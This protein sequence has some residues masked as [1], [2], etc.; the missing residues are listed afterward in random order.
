MSGENPRQISPED[1]LRLHPAVARFCAVVDWINVCVGQVIGFSIIIVTA[2][3]I[4]EIVLRSVVG[5]STIWSNESVIYLSAMTYLLAGGYALQHRAHVRIDLV[6]SML[7]PR[8]QARLDLATF[9]LFLLYTGT[10]IVVGGNMATE[11][12]LQH[13]T[14]GSPWNPPIW[15]VKFTVM[16]A[17]I[18]LLLQGIANLVRQVALSL[19]SSS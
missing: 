5:R 14:T 17:G 4:Y 19:R 18:L 10:L 13:E 8:N 12:M 16:F 1:E 3:V 11:S 2:M 6:H 7:S 9:L 15:P